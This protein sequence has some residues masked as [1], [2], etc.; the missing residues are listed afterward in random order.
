MNESV[1]TIDSLPESSFVQ[2]GRSLNEGSNNQVEIDQE[3]VAELCNMLTAPTCTMVVNKEAVEK[4]NGVFPNENHHRDTVEKFA[5]NADMHSK[6]FEDI[7]DI[8]RAY[9]DTPDMD[10]GSIHNLSSGSSHVVDESSNCDAHSVSSEQ[11]IVGL[12]REDLRTDKEE[13]QTNS[14]MSIQRTAEGRFSV[15]LCYALIAVVFGFLL[16]TLYLHHIISDQEIK[17]ETLETLCSS[18]AHENMLKVSNSFFAFEVNREVL[19]SI[20]SVKN[21]VLKTFYA[22]FPSIDEEQMLAILGKE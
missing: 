17:L 15:L 7:R 3:D 14:T 11:K 8:P 4:G 5:T 13:Y 6:L 16:Y 22:Q 21:I 20:G 18:Q 9:H 2:V 12:K 1:E 10:N 19:D